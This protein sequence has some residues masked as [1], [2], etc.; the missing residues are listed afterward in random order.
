M[1]VLRGNP[2]AKSYQR[3]LLKSLTTADETRW[4]TESTAWTRSPRRQASCLGTQR[5]T[6]QSLR[7]R[8]RMPRR[9]S[10]GHLGGSPGFRWLVGSDRLANPSLGQARGESAASDPRVLWQHVGVA[11]GNAAGLQTDVT[12]NLDTMPEIERTSRV[13]RDSNAIDF[14][15]PGLSCVEGGATRL[16]SFHAPD[17]AFPPV[18]GCIVSGN[19]RRASIS[20]TTERARCFPPCIRHGRPIIECKTLF[21]IRNSTV[22]HPV[23]VSRSSV[24][25]GPPAVS[26]AQ[27]TRSRR[28]P[29]VSGCSE[30][31]LH[32]HDD[33]RCWRTDLIVVNRGN[34]GDVQPTPPFTATKTKNELRIRRIGQRKNEVLLHRNNH[35]Q[36]ASF[37]PLNSCA[38]LPGCEVLVPVDPEIE[39][40]LNHDSE[41][42]EF[43]DTKSGLVRGGRGARHKWTTAARGSRPDGRA[44]R[45]GLVRRTS[46]VM[47]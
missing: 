23:G 2:T 28:S 20:S 15:P 12:V 32:T 29:L 6:Q 10:P 45:W 16:P 34:N 22:R 24:G 5:A 17:D 4:C 13:S 47:G 25:H 9:T 8:S 7:R 11:G 39:G 37:R 44:F 46:H 35:R 14:L 33:V 21:R 3:S 31:L 41:S 1:A 42:V 27:E 38:Q 43:P 18:S 36:T 26:Q 40:R 19:R 30:S